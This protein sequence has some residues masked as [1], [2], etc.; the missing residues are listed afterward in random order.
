MSEVCILERTMK[1]ENIPYMRSGFDPKSFAA[2]IWWNLPCLQFYGVYLRHLPRPSQTLF[3]HPPVPRHLISENVRSLSLKCCGCEKAHR[4][5]I[6]AKIPWC[7]GLVKL[8]KAQVL[9]HTTSCVVVVVVMWRCLPTANTRRE[10]ICNMSVSDK[11]L[12]SKGESSC[13]WKRVFLL[14][15]DKFHASNVDL[16]TSGRQYS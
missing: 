9:E 1:V 2:F 16:L 8:F 4:Q 7:T 3:M 11:F 12:T 15:N 10:H 5:G 6:K 13:L 14:L